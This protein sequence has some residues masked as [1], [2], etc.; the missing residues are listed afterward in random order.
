[1]KLLIFIILF[2]PFVSISQ[3]RVDLGGFGGVSY[4]LGD[5][6]KSRLFYASSPSA[7]AFLRYNFNPRYAV[8]G[9]LYYGSLKAKDKDF[10]N[11]YQQTRNQEFSTSLVDIALQAEFNFLPYVVGNNTFN[12]DNNSTYLLLGISY[13]MAPNTNEPNQIAIPLGM[14]Y[15]FNLKN[16]W[17]AG[18]EYSFRKTFTDGID[19][20]DG[21]TLLPETNKQT[22]FAHNKDW[23]SFFGVFISYM[24]FSQELSCNAYGSKKR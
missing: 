9:S 12:K 15:K 23:Y 16:K 21:K 10:S 4:Y 11:A 8:R 1:M 18:I 19:G 5:I 24:I 22:G 13:F 3:I 14:G 17:A 2:I 7:G 20:L 6:N